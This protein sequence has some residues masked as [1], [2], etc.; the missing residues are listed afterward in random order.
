MVSEQI[1]FDTAENPISVKIEGAGEPKLQLCIK[2]QDLSRHSKSFFRTYLLV[3]MT[4]SLVDE[5]DM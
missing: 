1:K 3:Q 4:M 5:A 2:D